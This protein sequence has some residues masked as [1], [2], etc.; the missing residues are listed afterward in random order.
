MKQSFIINDLSD[1]LDEGEGCKKPSEETG[2]EIECPICGIKIVEKSILR[3]HLIEEHHMSL[4]DACSVLTGEIPLS[5][6]LPTLVRPSA[7]NEPISYAD[8]EG[9]VPP[10]KVL[11]K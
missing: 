2:A 6:S 8:E 10:S 3:R 7:L 4:I 5:N 11:S 1:E 9:T